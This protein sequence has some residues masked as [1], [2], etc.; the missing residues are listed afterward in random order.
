MSH[1][2]QPQTDAEMMKAAAESWDEK[3][4]TAPTDKADKRMEKTEDDFIE[5]ETQNESVEFKNNSA[6][7]EK[8]L[9]EVGGMKGIQATLQEMP[10]DKKAKIM[11]KVKDIAKKTASERSKS[12]RP[13][14][15]GGKQKLQSEYEKLNDEFAATT[16]ERRQR[17]AELEASIEATNQAVLHPLDMALNSD[18][19][20]A[21]GL[22]MFSGLTG[23]T[24][25]VGSMISLTENTNLLYEKFQINREERK[26][27][28]K[29]REL[30]DSQ[31]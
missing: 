8:A 16:A 5:E 31:A 26:Y 15:N 29:V 6:A 10:E 12:S 4:E 24:S 23:L 17:K 3:V 28:K 1:E 25:F 18:S 11:E 2:K 22:E 20:L 30:R 19:I 13:K 21:G 9:A 14:K 7:T 27:Q